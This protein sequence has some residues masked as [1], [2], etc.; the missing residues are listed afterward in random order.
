MI[1]ENKNSGFNDYNLSELL[2]RIDERT[3]NMDSKLDTH[4]KSFNDHVLS[5][6]DEFKT[7]KDGQSNIKVSM[8]YYAGGL[9][10]FGI[11]LKILFKI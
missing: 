2:G 3:K 5:D 1:P 9:V 8:A 7:I 10:V 6:K 11:V 4:I